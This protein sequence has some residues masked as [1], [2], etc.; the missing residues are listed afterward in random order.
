MTSHDRSSVLSPTTNETPQTPAAGIQKREVAV[1]LLLL[2]AIFLSPLLP[3]TG[4]SAFDP[5]PVISTA[6][7]SSPTTY[8]GPE[9]TAGQRQQLLRALGDIHLGLIADAD[10]T[11]TLS[12][13]ACVDIKRQGSNDAQL[14]SVIHNRFMGPAL[15]TLTSLQEH[16]VL[17][18]I[19][20]TFCG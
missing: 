2:L 9:L 18:A 17:A 15:P 4:T 19:R 14:P 8:D 1:W 5:P 6:S 7:T 12:R 20:R 16:R 13:A 3:A 10:R 11:V